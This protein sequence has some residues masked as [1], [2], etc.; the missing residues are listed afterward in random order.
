VSDTTAAAAAAA[1]RDNTADEQC[2]VM[3]LHFQRQTAV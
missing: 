1:H 2:P 3:L